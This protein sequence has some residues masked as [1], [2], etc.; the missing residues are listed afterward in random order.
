MTDEQLADGTVTALLQNGRSENIWIQGES[1][2]ILSFTT[3]E[4]STADD[5][6]KVAPEGWATRAAATLSARSRK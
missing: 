3:L 1:T 5:S 6:E 4:E 2:P